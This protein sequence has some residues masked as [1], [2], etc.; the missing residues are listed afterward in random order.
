MNELK[1]RYFSSIIADSISQENRSKIV[2]YFIV[3]GLT[4]TR[5][6]KNHWSI[7][8]PGMYQEVKGHELYVDFTKRDKFCLSKFYALDFEVQL[9]EYVYKKNGLWY[10]LNFFWPKES[11]MGLKIVILYSLFSFCDCFFIQDCAD[12]KIQEALFCL[13]GEC[14]FYVHYHGFMVLHLCWHAY[15]Y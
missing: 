9:E 6:I 5:K 2:Q 4:D 15:H 1:E 12:K 3:R 10:Y 13:F 11:I 14:P 8:T 7:F